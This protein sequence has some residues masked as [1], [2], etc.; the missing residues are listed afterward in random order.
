MYDSFEDL[1]VKDDADLRD[2]DRIRRLCRRTNSGLY[3]PIAF[4]GVL[5]VGLAALCLWAAG[6]RI[7]MSREELWSLLCFSGFAA[8]MCLGMSWAFAQELL[9]SPLRGF[10]KDPTDYD[11][12]PGRIEE[13][14][15]QSNGS[16]STRARGSF[17]QGGIF[18]A[19]F[20]AQL[21]SRAIAERGEDKCLKPG[22]DW[23]DRKG[24]R[25]RLPLPVWVLHKRGNPRSGV[26]VGIP[27]DVAAK[28]SSAS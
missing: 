14:H 19:D 23:Y 12:S 4:C 10:L 5:G 7:A 27:A 9:Q 15:Y 22:D 25:A 13:A 3:A 1:A 18:L 6:A 21:W 11:F 26:L 2:Q 17:G 24:K 16:R 20:S 8:I 28:L